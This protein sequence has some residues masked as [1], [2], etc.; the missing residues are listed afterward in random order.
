[1]EAR[2]DSH[3]Q[4]ARALFLE[5]CNCAQ[6]VVV[7]YKDEL[8]LSRS[9]AMRMASAFGGGMSRLREVCGA[10]SG[11]CLVLGLLTG[12]DD[13]K[14]K[15]G[16]A[17][18]YARVQQLAKAFEAENGAIVCRELL[19]RRQ[20]RDEPVPAER[21][22]SYYHDRGCADYVACAARLID[23]LLRDGRFKANA[24]PKSND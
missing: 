8:G 10:M 17:M 6:A 7:A 23:E 19:K 3:E 5:G 9:E 21:T 12:Y 13:P 11:L 15:D 22:E 14:D 18:E 24:A 4:R 20:R 1:M 16:K 2:T